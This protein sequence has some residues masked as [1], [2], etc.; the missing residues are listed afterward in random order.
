[1][2]KQQKYFKTTNGGGLF[3]L[4]KPT[5]TTKQKTKQKTPKALINVKNPTQACFQGNPHQNIIDVTNIPDI[6][7][8]KASKPNTKEFLFSN[9]FLNPHSPEKHCLLAWNSQSLENHHQSELKLLDQSFQ[10]TW[11]L[12][13]QPP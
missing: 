6:L 3:Y 13:P 7:L 12:I 8:K 10:V 4:K 1:M 5:K 2:D 9:P 11:W